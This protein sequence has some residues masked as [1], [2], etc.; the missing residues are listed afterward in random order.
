MHRKKSIFKEG[1]LVQFHLRKRCFSRGRHEKSQPIAD[2]PFNI[3]KKISD[4]GYKVELLGNYGVLITFNVADLFRYIVNEPNSNS[5]ENP[6]QQ[7]DNDTQ[8]F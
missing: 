4:N 3:L 5:K 6:F 8:K 2:G 1:D 7:R